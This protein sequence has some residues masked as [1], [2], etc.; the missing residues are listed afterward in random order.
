MALCDRIRLAN[1]NGATLSPYLSVLPF[2]ARCCFVAA[3]AT[4]LAPAPP[5]PAAARD[6]RATAHN[7]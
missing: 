1:A 5:P 2:C 3:L 6:A 7:T 4:C